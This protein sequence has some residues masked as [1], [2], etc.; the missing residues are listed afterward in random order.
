VE[1]IASPGDGLRRTGLGCRE[2]ARVWGAP[3]APEVQPIGVPAGSDG[4]IF[5]QPARRVALT[6]RCEQ[7]ELSECQGEERTVEMPRQRCT[8]GAV[9]WVTPFVLAPRIVEEREE[10]HDEG[11]CRG[12]HFDQAV[13]DQSNVLPVPRAMDARVRARAQRLNLANKRVVVW[14]G[15]NHRSIFRSPYQ[16]AGS[17][18]S[19][20]FLK[21]SA[22][23][24]V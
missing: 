17:S 11:I 12:H 15:D 21:V 13:A 22:R 2:I 10:E 16:F 23:Y 9:L 14:D 18:V 8:P 6:C 20:R 3:N 1:Q 24:A 19:W 7:R 4:W 5:G